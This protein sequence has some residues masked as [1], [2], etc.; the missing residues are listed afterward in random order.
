M[1]LAAD[2]A[3]TIRGEIVDSYCYAGRGIHGSPHTACA[4]R[5]ARKGMP[6]VLIED[7]S[8]RVYQLMPPG[9]ET[10]MPANAIAAAGTVRTVTGR[11]FV[12]SGARY[13]TADAIG[14]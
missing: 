9:D 12:N 11:M 2:Q 3:V 7:G 14:K 10:A 5:C 13:L 1:S 4:L 8:R 6:L